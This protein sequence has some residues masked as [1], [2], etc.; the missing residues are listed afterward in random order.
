MSVR[1]SARI[2]TFPDDMVFYG[3]LAEQY[4]QVGNAVPCV[5]AKQLAKMVGQFFIVNP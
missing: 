4:K 2:Q 3:S 5:L 1:E